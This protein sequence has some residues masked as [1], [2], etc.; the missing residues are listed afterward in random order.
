MNIA[1]CRT[2]CGH[3]GLPL[4]GPPRERVDFVRENIK[5][6]PFTLLP[7]PLTADVLS[8]WPL[9]CSCFIMFHRHTHTHT[10]TDHCAASRTPSVGISPSTRAFP[11]VFPQFPA[12][13]PTRRRAYS[14]RGAMFSQRLP[15]L[16]RLR[17]SK[18]K[19]EGA[20]LRSR[21]GRSKDR[22]RSY[23]RADSRPARVALGRLARPIPKSIEQHPLGARFAPRNT[24]FP[25]D[26]LTAIPPMR[27]L[28]VASVVAPPR[29]LE[30]RGM[31]IRGARED[32]RDSSRLES[33]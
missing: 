25:S 6:L 4:S 13:P 10:H 29:V 16:P 21:P 31:L 2:P 19:P 5:G 14:R 20:S 12:A 1:P 24:L 18:F 23:H 30:Y 3:C 26:R 17:G 32:A 15:S 7:C 8:L 33:V 9:V 11:F 28:A 27:K 22:R